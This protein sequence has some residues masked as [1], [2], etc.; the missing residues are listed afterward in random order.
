VGDADGITAIPV[1]RLERVIEGGRKAM[2]KEVEAMRLADQAA[3]NVDWIEDM[4]KIVHIGQDEAE[5]AATPD[6]N[7]GMR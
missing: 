3:I 4:V 5:R 6:M 1:E 7:Y 2:A